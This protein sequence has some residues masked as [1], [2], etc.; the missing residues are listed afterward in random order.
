MR[1]T[2][3]EGLESGSPGRHQKHHAKDHAV[4]HDDEQNIQSCRQQ[5]H[6]QAIDDVPPDIVTCQ[7]GNAHVLTVG[8][9]N[10]VSPT[11]PKALYQEDEWKADDKTPDHSCQAHVPGD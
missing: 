3:V 2:C 8:M 7:S 11:I 5:G 6:S 1:S 10:D 4:R 9:G